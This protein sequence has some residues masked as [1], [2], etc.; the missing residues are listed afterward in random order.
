MMD[1]RLSFLR[2]LPFIL[3]YLDLGVVGAGYG[4]WE[5]IKVISL[6]L[7]IG[8]ALG[9]GFSKLTSYFDDYPLEIIFSIILFYGSF[10]LA[11]AV[12]AS[13]VIAVVVATLIFGNYG[14]K[15]GMSP[16]TK[17]N[18]NN[19][20]EVTAL[21][22]NSIVFLMRNSRKRDYYPIRTRTIGIKEQFGE[23]F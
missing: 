2:F 6:G 8:G 1:L 18:I 3:S 20:W 7:I 10:I 23:T 12:H 9:Y 13:G 16:T 22:A 15:I 17:L 14:A 19:F 4:L 11:E 21:L 5:F